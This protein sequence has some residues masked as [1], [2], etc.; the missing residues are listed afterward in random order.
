MSKDTEEQAIR[1]I[2][3]YQETIERR[4][5]KPSEHQTTASS[6]DLWSTISRKELGKKD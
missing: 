5:R 6:D 4:A 2:A 1:A 3:T